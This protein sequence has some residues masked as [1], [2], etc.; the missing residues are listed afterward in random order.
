MWSLERDA[1][2]DGDGLIG[3][4]PKRQKGIKKTERNVC[5]HIIVHVTISW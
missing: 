1:I 4:F 2:D 3:A 5:H